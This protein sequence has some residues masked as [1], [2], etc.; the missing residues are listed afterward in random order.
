MRLPFFEPIGIKP[1]W[2]LGFS[3]KISHFDFYTYRSSQIKDNDRV[4]S[5]VP[6]SRL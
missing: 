1:L 5:N 3:P 4:R 6:V 2:S